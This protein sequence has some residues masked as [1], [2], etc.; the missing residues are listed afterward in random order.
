MAAALGS[1]A[2]L[3]R[4]LTYI[5][6]SYFQGET[7]KLHEYGIATEVFGRSKTT[8]NAGEDAIVRVEAH[9]LRKRLKD[10]YEGEGKDHPVQLSIP[11]GSY[12]PVFTRSALASADPEVEIAS[13]PARSG[14]PWWYYG[15]ATLALALIVVSAYEVQRARI[16]GKKSSVATE[17]PNVQHQPPAAPLNLPSYAET[18]LRIIAGYDGKPQID[19]A[20]NTWQSDRYSHF[21]GNWNR[22]AGFVAKTSDQLAFKAGAMASS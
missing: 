16:G 5:G 8:F 4:L 10:Y 15:A 1:S 12:V 20:G 18:P 21:G 19:S 22:P 17:T 14:V 11:S 6:E 3:Q 7:E 13:A 9:R 2:R